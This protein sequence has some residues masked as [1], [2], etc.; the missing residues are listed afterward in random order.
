MFCL[1]LEN[2]YFSVLS[3]SLVET[4]DLISKNKLYY[5][6]FLD[7]QLALIFGLTIRSLIEA[8]LIFFDNVSVYWLNFM[9]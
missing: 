3:S 5:L 9:S 8:H 6:L 2:L 4:A 1:I 7:D